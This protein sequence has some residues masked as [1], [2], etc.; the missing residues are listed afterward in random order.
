MAKHKA[1]LW[2]RAMR[3][4]MPV[5]AVVFPGATGEWAARRFLMPRRFPFKPSEAAW[6]EKMERFSLKAGSHKVQ[7]YR[8]GTGPEIIFVHGWEGRAM[9]FEAFV[10]AVSEA[11]FTFVAFDAWGHG[12]SGGKQSHFLEFR[13]A[14]DAAV[15]KSTNLAGA[16][17]HSLGA[18]ALSFSMKEGAEIPRLVTIGAPSIGQDIL[19]E[20]CKIINAPKSVQ[21]HIRQKAVDKF[22]REFEDFA[23]ERTFVHTRPAP[24]LSIHDTDDKEAGMQHLEKLIEIRPEIKVK[25]TN[26]LGHRRILKDEGAVQDVAGFFAG[27]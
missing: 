11:G 25:I 19:D 23:M 3:A 6:L 21:K 13:A 4:L 8:Y 7:G 15:D 27:T 1:P 20:F 10:P 14:I 17:G 5:A 24:V 9:Q 2:F 12:K 16:V 18:A 22:N 26:G